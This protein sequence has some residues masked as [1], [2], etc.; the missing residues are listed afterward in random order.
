MALPYSID[1]VVRTSDDAAVRAQFDARTLASL[2]VLALIFLLVNVPLTLTGL[3]QGQW[4]RFVLGLG[5]FVLAALVT[6]AVRKGIPRRV[7]TAIKQRVRGTAI[8]FA[9]AETAI[10]LLW[11]APSQGVS[12]F[13][14]F[15]GMFL[16]SYRLLPAE[17][18]LLYGGV[19]AIATIVS[20]TMPAPRESPAEM[21]IPPV[22]LNAMSMMLAL[23]I[24]RRM[25]RNVLGQWAERRASAR[26]QIRMRDELQYA[27]ELQLS[28]LPECSPTLP[29]ADICSIS[30]PATEVGGDYYDYFVDHDRVA[31]V[32]GDVAG[33]G[34]ASGI[35]L[36]AMRSGF[37]LLRDAL[38]DPAA[39][40]RRLHDL[41]SQTSRRRML[42][43]VSVVLLDHATRR[44][45]IASAGHP[46]ILL[47]RADGSVAAI[48]LYAPPLGVR[49][50]V[51][52]PQ[53]TLEVAGGDVFVLHSDGVYETR[54]AAG[55]EYGLDRLA[56]VV[57]RDGGGTAEELRNAILRDV[58]SFRGAT[59]AEDDVTVVVCR[60]K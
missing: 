23:Y 19:A 10:V 22:V 7:A 33:H 48:E 26:E 60:V 53:R 4:H 3:G 25:R 9:L 27:R 37:T 28:M 51:E 55:E 21:V 24:S 52:I 43:T 39:V 35:V 56:D 32:C 44:A 8:V 47:R 31:L 5:G 45:I 12:I 41:V 58:A 14:V 36:S 1:E 29:W 57:Q 54:N 17:H 42:V 40:L 6:L 50:P 15:I 11:S 59:E 30:I 18:V 13:A 16:V 2:R 46:P 49:L 34:M 20:L 38:H